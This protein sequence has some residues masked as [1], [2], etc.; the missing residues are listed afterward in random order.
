M[1]AR[2]QP[3][4][5]HSYEL[6]LCVVGTAHAVVSWRCAV[7]GPQ[8]AA[9]G[10]GGAP[11]A[12]VIGVQ[13]WALSL[14]ATAR[15]WGVRSRPATHW[16]WAPWAGVEARSPHSGRGP[17][18]TAL[19]GGGGSVSVGVPLTELCVP[20]HLLPC[21]SSVRDVRA[22]RFCGTRWLLLLGSCQ[23]A[24]VGAGGVPL[25]RAS[26]PRVAAPRLVRSYGSRCFSQVSRCRGA[27]PYQRLLPPHLLST[28][29][30]TRS[31]AERRAHGSCRRPRPRRQH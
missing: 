19:C 3:H 8:E 12:S 6:A 16:L 11:R 7:C 29:R 9:R 28:A 26:W 14:P 5:A 25:W 21:R 13:S 18:G 17:G 15:P 24:L 20:W 31:P 2:H 22:S 10:G 27:F 1:G 30:G 4:S 23:C